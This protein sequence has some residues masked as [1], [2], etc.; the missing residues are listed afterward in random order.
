MRTWPALDVGRLTSAASDGSDLLQAAL[1]DYEVAAIA[2]P[3]LDTWQVF[4]DNAHERDRAATALSLQFP[5]LSFGAID[6]AD[7]DWVARSQADL[8]AVRVGNIVV[9]PPW[10]LP[11]TGTLSLDPSGAFRPPPTGAPLVI[12]IRPSMGFGTAHHATTRLC[13][14]ALQRLDLQGRTAVDVGTGSGVLAIAAR[15]LGAASVVGI[16]D[17]PD[18]LHSAQENL[19][20]N[21]DV[22]VALRETDARSTG[23]DAFDLVVANLTGAL[24]VAAAPSLCHLTTRGGHLILSGLLEDEEADV[25]A[26][27]TGCVV[28]NRSQ[29]GEWLCLV[30]QRP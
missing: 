5:G 13:L 24:L 12:T 22:D 17:D 6:V 10:D 9:A 23:L 28:H 18:A 2:E 7:D 26:A 25:V 27:F 4:F 16:D 3:S 30:L 8:R 15:R 14:A 20:L 19:G 11:A 1:A 21:S 29:E